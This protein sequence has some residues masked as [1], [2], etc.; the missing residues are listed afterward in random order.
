MKNCIIILENSKKNNIIAI[1]IYFVPLMTKLKEKSE[2]NIDA[3]KVLINNYLY[4]PS[5][6]CSYYSCFQLMKYALKKIAGI[7]YEDLGKQIRLSEQNT[8]K[9]VINEIGKIIKRKNAYD[10][11]YFNNNIRELKALREEADYENVEILIDKSEKALKKAKE[12]RL[13]LLKEL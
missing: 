8:H 13:S 11:R 9:F 5:V 1:Q 10:F 3:A 4:A 2:F 6:H 12:L 7:E